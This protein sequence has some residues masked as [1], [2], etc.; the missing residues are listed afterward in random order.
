MP[1][2]D[3]SC[4]LSEN[5]T[6]KHLGLLGLAAQ[7]PSGQRYISPGSLTSTAPQRASWIEFPPVKG[8]HLMTVFP[9]IDVWVHFG[10]P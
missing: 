8:D 1:P 4:R 10:P 6:D 7:P 9:W 2:Q 5:H 3:S